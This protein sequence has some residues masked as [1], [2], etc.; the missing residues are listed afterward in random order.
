[1]KMGKKKV[2]G[3]TDKAE[4]IAKVRLTSKQ[5]L[6]LVDMQNNGGRHNRGTT[7]LDYSVRVDLQALGLIQEGMSLTA[8]EQKAIMAEINGLWKSIPALVKG[9]DH[10]SIGRIM[11]EIGRKHQDIEAK[12]W[13]LTDAAKEYLVHGKVVVSR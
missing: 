2:E 7:Y 13:V 12:T 8:Q 3:T 1:M 4:V 10:K 11:G 9:K 6:T 5:R